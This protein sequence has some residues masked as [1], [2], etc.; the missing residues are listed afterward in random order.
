MNFIL[1]FLQCTYL[2]CYTHGMFF[3]DFG[4]HGLNLIACYDHVMFASQQPTDCD[5]LRG[6]CLHCRK[7]G[8]DLHA[9]LKAKGLS[10]NYS[11]MTTS[12]DV[13]LQ[14]YIS[15]QCLT[16]GGLIQYSCH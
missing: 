13:R 16:S 3:S 4:L 5:F 1:L 6:V 9:L 2:T 10:V 14:M 11:N 8:Y 12:S 7:I 15:P